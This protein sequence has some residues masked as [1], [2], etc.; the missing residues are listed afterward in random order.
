MSIVYHR[1]KTNVVVH[2]LSRFPMGSSTHVEEYLRE[3]S[4]DVYRLA[5]LGVRLMGSTEGGILVTNEVE[6]SLVSYE[7]E[8]QDQDPIFLDLKKNFIRKEY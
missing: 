3:L 2:S 1:G 7:K 4:K 6:S 5:R 8:K